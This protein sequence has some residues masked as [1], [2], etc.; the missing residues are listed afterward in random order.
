MPRV[1]WARWLICISLTISACPS[2]LRAEDRDTPLDKKLYEKITVE[3]KDKDLLTNRETSIQSAL[4]WLATKCNIPFQVNEGA[5]EPD[6][7]GTAKERLAAKLVKPGALPLK[8]LS[9]AQMLSN[10]LQRMPGEGEDGAT[11]LLRGDHVEITTRRLARLEVFGPD[12]SGPWMPPVNV[13]FQDVPLADALKELAARS[14]INV[15][16]DPY[17]MSGRK[18]TVTLRLH[19]TPVDTAARL[20]ADQCGLTSVRIDYSICVTTLDRAP[21]LAWDPRPCITQPKATWLRLDAQ[22]SGTVDDDSSGVMHKGFRLLADP[23]DAATKRGKLRKSYKLFKDQKTTVKEALDFVALRFRFAYELNEAAFNKGAAGKAEDSLN[24]PLIGNKPFH[25]DVDMTVME[26]LQRITA[27]MPGEGAD[28]ATFLVRRDHIEITTIDGLRRE[29]YSKQYHGPYLQIVD[30]NWKNRPLDEALAELTEKASVN[31]V[32][33]PRL[34]DAAKT[35]VSLR[36]SNVDVDDVIRV[37]ALKAGLRAYRIDNVFFVTPVWHASELQKREVDRQ[38][39]IAA[40][41]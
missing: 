2:I 41:E 33:D 29:I 16:R 38:R 12:F 7:G 9:L 20:A 37:M 11:F 14:G 13:D 4:D 25:V 23:S 21:R 27:R 36:V 1:S 26:L 34:H 17:S 18:R 5:F 22:P 19:N 8:D 10:I 15:W 32:I 28:A 6:A 39:G 31:V 40:R 35:C 24:A 30:V 3:P